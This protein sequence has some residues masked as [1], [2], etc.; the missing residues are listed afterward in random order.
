MGGR[1]ADKPM[2]SSTPTSEAIIFSRIY[3]LCAQGLLAEKGRE[4]R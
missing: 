1:L 3:P 2:E 4:Y